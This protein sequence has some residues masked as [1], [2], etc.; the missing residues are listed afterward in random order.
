M[1]KIDELLSRGVEN[2]ISNKETLEKALRSGKKLNVYFGIDPTAV[3]IHI[4]NA[5]P[6]RRLQTFVE[7]GH[8]VTFI[9]GDFTA[10][11]GDTSDKES[12]R[13][14]LT[15]EQIQKNFKDYKAQAEKLVDFSKIELHHNSEWLKNLR[16]EEIVEL[17][18]HY[19]LND[20]ISRE[21]I[22]KRLAS[23]GSVRL[24]EVIYPVMQGYDSYH[25]DT[26][27]QIGGPDQTFNMQAG[28]VLQKDFRNKESFV[29][30]TGYLEGTDGRKM[31]KS[32]GN[33]I[34]LDDSPEEMFG[35][36]MSLKDDLIIQYF[37]LATDL[38]MEKVGEIKKRLESG[39]NPMVLKKELAHEIVSEL[40]SK[41]AADKAQS[42]WEKTFQKGEIGEV[43]EIKAES[44]EDLVSK[45]IVASKSEWKRL[46]DQGAI[47]VDGKKLESDKILPGTYRIGKKKFIKII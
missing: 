5:V 15:K 33:A 13:P 18:R 19:S 16:F 43:E 10:L 14:V 37:T 34:W 21:L 46:V 27:I 8:H 29:L 39:E 9:I 45:G 23:G 44:V 2:I 6:L 42:A 30:V 11:I 4:G 36:V 31:S 20:F 32:W 24:D 41:Q 47:E 25:L 26:D 35:K 7:L 1:D 40:H 17:I 38:P 28:R 22:K 12:E 3:H